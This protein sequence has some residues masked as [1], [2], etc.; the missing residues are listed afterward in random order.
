MYINICIVNH[1]EKLISQEA[2]GSPEPM[3]NDSAARALAVILERKTMPRQSI[4]FL[5][6][7]SWLQTQVDSQEFTNKSDVVNNL[8]RKAREIE[9]I[10]VRLI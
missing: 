4:S 9:A 3:L 8:I 5:P 7:E 1:S 2:A 10:R 6:N